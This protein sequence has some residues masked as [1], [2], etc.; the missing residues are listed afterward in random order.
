ML[1]HHGVAA[2]LLIEKRKV[3]QQSFVLF[4][5]GVTAPLNFA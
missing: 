4:A 1:T 3:R 2:L 5:I